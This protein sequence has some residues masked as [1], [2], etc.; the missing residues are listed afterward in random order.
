MA[1]LK[2][3][4]EEFKDGF[5]IKYD[6]F[7]MSNQFTVLSPEGRHKDVATLEQAL[8]ELKLIGGYYGH[9]ISMSIQY[10]FK[11]SA[12]R[13][14]LR[15]HNGNLVCVLVEFADG[16]CIIDPGNDEPMDIVKID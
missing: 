9:K 1:G 3:W 5:F 6:G 15:K 13:W 16:W 11:G 2:L 4:M 7:R 14:N 8:N 10:P 12:N